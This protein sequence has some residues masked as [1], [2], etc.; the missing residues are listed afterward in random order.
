MTTHTPIVHLTPA[1]TPTTTPAITP[2]IAPA[3]GWRRT[4]VR[5]MP[6]F[7]GF[8]AGGLAAKLIVGP[9][10]SVGAALAGGAISGAALGIAQW[11]GV[12]RTGLAPEPW[13]IAT[14]AGLALGLAAGASAVDFDTTTGALA[15]QGAICGAIVGAA[16]ATILFRR[17]GRLAVALPAALSALWALGWTITASAGVDV[18]AQYTVFGASGAVVVTA[19]TSV[20]AL[21]LASRTAAAQHRTPQ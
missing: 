16:Q 8:P 3:T 13:V 9:I 2:A 15:A 19:A 10:D 7:L 11:L 6:T 18:E 5:W 20:L 21:A 14:A 4:V 12:R 1:S 17:L